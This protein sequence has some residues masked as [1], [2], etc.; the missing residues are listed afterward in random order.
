M[1]PPALP[2]LLPVYLLRWSHD[3]VAMEMCLQSCCLI[4]DIFSDS[5]FLCLTEHVAVL[6]VQDKRINGPRDASGSEDTRAGCAVEVESSKSVDW[7]LSPL[8]V[9]K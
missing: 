1:P 5:A 4:K 2:V 8:R 7:Q 6:M 9:V 3:F